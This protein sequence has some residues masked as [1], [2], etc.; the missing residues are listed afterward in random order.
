MKYKTINKKN[1][2]INNTRSVLGQ[3]TNWRWYLFWIKDFIQGGAIYKTYKELQK[4]YINSNETNKKKID[5]LLNEAKKNTKFYA[6]I[7]SNNIKDFP[8]INKYIINQNYN[9]I[10]S[11]KYT[12][13]KLHKMCTSGSTGTPFEILQNSKKRKKVLAELIFFNKL[14][15]YEFGKRQVFF[16]VWTE[17][18]K[19]NKIQSFLQN[20]IPID[21]SNLDDQSIEHI[22]KYIKNDKHINN[23]LSYASTLDLVSKY[24]LNKKMKPK[25][26]SV[27]SIISGSELLQDTTRK[28]LKRLFNCNIVSRYSNQE[29]GILAQECIEHQ[30]MHLNNT[31]YYIEFLKL[32]SDED[33]TEGEMARIVVTDL[34][35]YAMP[36]IRYDTGDIAIYNNVSKCGKKERLITELYGR[37][38]DT[39]FDT[40][41][42]ALSPHVITNN[43]WGVKGMLQF[44]FQQKGINKY[45]IIINMEENKK[46]DIEELKEKFK[47]ILGQDALIEVEYVE[48]IPILSSGKR[49]YIENL[50]KVMK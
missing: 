21:I 42:N 22:A 32:D 3:I 11:K 30:E 20:L 8:V 33:A 43:M 49:K 10:C 45:N 39:I 27:D 23:I 48:E 16:R 18:N 44:K 6:K 5:E 38:V 1:Y 15:G 26:F 12:N 28:N 47:R 9:E 2:L 36:M 19:K 25:D 24:M 14:C 35:N 50:Y 29:N 17:K 4:D 31:N 34:Y 37:R 13:K 41:G 40:K 7:K 46:I